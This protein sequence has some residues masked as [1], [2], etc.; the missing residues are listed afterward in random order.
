[1]G[2]EDMPAI[3][4]DEP[5][6]R[7]LSRNFFSIETVRPT[8]EGIYAFLHEQPG[9][10]LLESDLEQLLFEASINVFDHAGQ[11]ACKGSISVSQDAVTISD[12][13]PGIVATFVN[14]SVGRTSAAL[15]S[16]SSDEQLLCHI[17]RKKCSSKPHKGAG[18][19][20][21]RILEAAY[22]IRAKKLTLESSGFKLTWR[23]SR[24]SSTD[25]ASISSDQIGPSP[26]LE[27]VPEVVGTTWTI[28][29]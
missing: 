19:G 24:W 11:S 18:L 15:R 23:P 3:H 5:R 17:V 10:I 7:Q 6:A 16:S 21:L 12:G 13:G 2:V 8:Q 1:M 26:V 29:R 20:T 9:E 4:V 22:N 14:S 25:L 27:K 28:A